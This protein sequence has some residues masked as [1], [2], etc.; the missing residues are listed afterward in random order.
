MIKHRE[1]NRIRRSIIIGLVQII[2]VTASLLI[3]AYSSNKLEKELAAYNKLIYYV[4]DLKVESYTF[5][6]VYYE[7]QAVKSENE[8][9][10][11]RLATISDAML[12]DME[13]INKYADTS[14]GYYSK[15]LKVED[16]ILDLSNAVGLNMSYDDLA[17]KRQLL[18]SVISDVETTLNTESTSEITKFKELAIISQG[19]TIFAI[20]SLI[21][22]F[23]INVKN[24]FNYKKEMQEQ[25]MLDSCIDELTRLWNRKYVDKILPDMAIRS[26]RGYLFMVDMDHFKTINDTLGHNIGDEVLRDFANVAKNCLRPTD[27]ICRLGGDEF[28]IF[29][30]NISKDEQATAIYRRLRKAVKERFEGTPKDI[31][32]LSCGAIAYDK[33]LDFNK[34]YV[35]AD[36]ALYYVKEHGRNNFHIGQ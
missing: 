15:L 9:Y 29:S 2:L 19:L 3:T 16:Y 21:S 4:A 6:N 10:E 13:K 17:K 11:T 20:L 36:E 23:A 22:L 7:Y 14:G 18:A 34:N 1:I 28:M 31:V 24:L 30:P 27:I 8:D 33:T 32:T 35:R 25:S 12:E 5:S 26:N